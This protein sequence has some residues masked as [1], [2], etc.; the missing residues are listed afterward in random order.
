MRFNKF[1]LLLT[2][3]AAISGDC[4]HSLSAQTI[5]R[6]LRVPQN[7]QTRII[8]NSLSAMQEGGIVLKFSYEPDPQKPLSR[9]IKNNFND[10]TSTAKTGEDEAIDI[11]DTT[12]MLE[13]LLLEAE[14][15]LA[16]TEIASESP[17][18]GVSRNEAASLT[19]AIATTTAE[20]GSDSAKLQ[21]SH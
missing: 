10:A 14:A 15:S 19:V 13:K 21:P 11:G 4:R 3:L 1:L 2:A 16:R 5:S 12:I 6:W 20:T 9:L 18:Y 8:R 17:L 7:G